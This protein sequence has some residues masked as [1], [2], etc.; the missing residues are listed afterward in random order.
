MTFD[1]RF[2]LSLLVRRLHGV[3][4]IVGVA[5][6][7]GLLLAQTLPPVYRAQARLLMTS[8]QIPD[9]LAA[10]TVRSSPA[11]ILISIHE[12]LVTQANLLALSD[13]F[14]IHDDAPDMPDD[15]V[16]ADMRARIGLALPPTD[17]RTGVVVVSFD[18]RDA[19]LSA[20]VTGAL[21]DQIL[22]QD[23]QLR[24]GVSGGTLSFFEQEVQR[25]S[26][27]LAQQNARI[28][29]F[30]QENR[31]ALPESMDYR[32]Q[33]QSAQQE[34]LLQLD[35]E[36]AS[37]RDRRLRL[38]EL[39][40]RTGRLDPAEA[41]LTPEQA[42][43]E[44]LRQALASA[45]VVY[46]PG[47]PRLRAL[48]T[49]VAALDEAVRRQA[50]FADRAGGLTSFEL[51]IADIDAQIDFLARQKAQLQTDLAALEESIRATPAIALTLGKLQGDFANLRVQYD[52]AVQSLAEARMGDRIEV[53]AR[54]QRITVIDPARPPSEPAAPNRKLVVAAGFGAGVALA[55]AWLFLLDLLDRT[56]RRPSELVA[57][58]GIT[59]F[60]TVPY[61]ATPAERQGHRQRVARG[62]A[63]GAVGLGLLL[64]A[65]LI[66]LAM[67]K[68]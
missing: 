22:A 6:L 14:G 4:A 8:P 27:E 21:V 67:G 54:G 52:Q 25:L 57:A 62:I 30:E 23:V 65:G 15:A 33:R 49:Q 68:G 66:L 18:A 44:R 29:M 50:G 16:V 60:G 63:A 20:Q 53:T 46:A 41:A 64:G 7:A 11:E 34:R 36:L 42:Q 47:N 51:Q 31:T 17:N 43:L 38:A 24:T 2:Y 19:Q 59:P 48:Q 61:I 5:T 3:A 28:L 12:R 37:L 10:S 56:L 13:R 55:G 39:Y 45:L 35:R 1:P 26:E 32:R 9:E 58:L 40:E